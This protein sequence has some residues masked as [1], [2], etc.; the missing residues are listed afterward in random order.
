MFFSPDY[1]LEIISE[2]DYP[3]KILSVEEEL[4]KYA[5]TGELESFDGCKLYYEYYLVENSRAS[6][7]IVHGFTEFTRKYHE[8]CWYFMHMGYNV[9][10]YDQRGHGLS[11]RTVEDLHLAHV[12]SF[13]DYVKDLEIFTDR[14]VIPNSDR[15]SLLLY[16]QSMGGAISALYLSRHSELIRRAVLSS[17]MICVKAYNIPRKFLM[18]TVKR[19]AVK[20]GWNV[21]FKH[22]GEFTSDVNFERTSDM[23]RSR[24]EHNMKLRTAD[25]RYQNSSSTNRWMYE[26]LAVTDT[27]LNPKTAKS[28]QSDVLIISAEKDSVVKNRHQ[29]LF[30]KMLKNSRFEKISGAKH[31]LYNSSGD[32]LLEYINLLFDFFG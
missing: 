3:E 18:F 17:P 27:L 10:I 13:D 2:A 12:D 8:L 30:S 24:F 22:A 28:I 26:S 14:I 31:S 20:D 19:S 15:K 29:K 5:V 11:G 7:I 32:S 21:K 1:K 4:S 23:S 9:F 25:K 6:I 16:S